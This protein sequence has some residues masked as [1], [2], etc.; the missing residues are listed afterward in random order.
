MDKQRRWFLPLALLAGLTACTGTEDPSETPDLSPTGETESPSETPT[1]ATPTPTSATPTQAPDT[2]GDGLF[3]GNDN[4]PPLDN[5]DQADL[6]Q[7]GIGDLCDED[8]DGDGY[9]PENPLPSQVDCDDRDAQ[10]HPSA[11]ED[12]CSGADTNCDGSVAFC[13]PPDEGA[14]QLQVESCIGPM[15]FTIAPMPCKI[16]SIVPPIEMMAPYSVGWSSHAP[17]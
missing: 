6:D 11:V 16:W 7:D 17:P 12:S 4:C 2:D 10:V 15:T 8:V 3:D 5:S 14:Q 1:S 9:L 13:F